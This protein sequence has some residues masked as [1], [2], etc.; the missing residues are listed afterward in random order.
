[1]KK[2][3]GVGMILANDIFDGGGLATDCHVLPATTVGA[4]GGDEIRKYIRGFPGC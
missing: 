1:M 2:A 4:T 3:V